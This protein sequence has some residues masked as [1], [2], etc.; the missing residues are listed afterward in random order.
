MKRFYIQVNSPDG[1]ANFIIKNK[2]V[3]NE[4]EAKIRVMKSYRFKEED[5]LRVSEQRLPTDYENFSTQS[6]H[7]LIYFVQELLHRRDEVV[8]IG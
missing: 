7:S 1:I 4:N 8:I 3:T 6:H 2:Y 5:I